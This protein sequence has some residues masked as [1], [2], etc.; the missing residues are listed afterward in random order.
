MRAL[1][2]KFLG[3][4]W[5][6]KSDEFVFSFA[7]ILTLAKSLVPT[8][9]NILRV[10]ASFFDPLGFIA[11]ITARVK[12]IFQ[13]LCLD[14]NE[15]DSVISGDLLM[16]WNQFLSDLEIIN[17]LR[18]KRFSFVEVK[19][20][21]NSITMHGFC[22]SSLKVY[23]A[24]VY[25]QIKTSIGI[26][27]CFLAA[28]TKVAPLKGITIPRLELL[29]CA[30]LSDLI[31]QIDS[32]IMKRLLIDKKICWT[33]SEVALCWIKGKSRRWKPWVENR[34]VKVRKVVDCE[35]WYHVA[36]G[37]NPADIATRICCV[38]DFKRWFSGPQMLYENDYD[39][40]CFDVNKK[41]NM[42]DVV[43][44]SRKV[45]KFRDEVINVN[46][47]V[48]N[49]TVS[50]SNCLKSNDVNDV[51]KD[52]SVICNIAVEH[53]DYVETRVGKDQIEQSNSNKETITLNNPT[54]L[55]N[56]IIDIN[57]FSNLCKLINTT[58]YVFRFIN[59]LKA[60]VKNKNDSIILEQTITIEEY[61]HALKGWIK[62]EQQLLQKRKDFQ[63]LQ[64]SL[65][66]FLCDDGFLRLQGRFG[67]ASLDYDQKYPIL[68]RSGE[69]YLTR[70]VVMDAHKN[71]LHHGIE[72]SLNYIRSNY[73]I[74]KGRKTVKDILRRCVICKRYQG[75]AML[76]PETPDLPDFRVNNVHSFQHSWSRFC[77]TIVHKRL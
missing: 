40:E 22:D 13:M 45:D 56:E 36:G 60:R 73:W 41:L 49:D 43:V 29:G 25:I 39:V 74:I 51:S 37:M 58:G 10:A 27:V 35:N 15:W 7:D 59:N 23:C 46:V 24:V 75:R 67:N 53:V 52:G 1:G 18:V 44:E 76:P 16:V 19:E 42:V 6:V 69:S 32:A 31:Q 9:R 17:S 71:V 57:R 28:K 64:S 62:A 77:R 2:E 66:L 11:P 5:D 20:E 33:D 8:K 61:N 72:T 14:K 63:K 26:R 48:D 47:T 12:N 50:E 4:E 38:D 68:L 30:L 3:V 65:K 34:V 55:I 54:H 70:L 21:I